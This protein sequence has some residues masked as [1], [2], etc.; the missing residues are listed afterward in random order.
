MDADSRHHDHR[1]NAIAFYY[2]EHPPPHFHVRFAE[3]RAQIDIE[4]LNMINGSKSQAHIKQWAAIRGEQLR[5][6]WAL[7][8]SD[9][10]PG[11][12]T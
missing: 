12:I 11:Q 5:F 8:Q 3:F 10:P 9:K 4:T 7:C 2:D 1:W 6:A